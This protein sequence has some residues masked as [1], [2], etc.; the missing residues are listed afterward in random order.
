M[1]GLQFV[2]DNGLV[3]SSLIERYHKNKLHLELRK[4]GEFKLVTPA[5][6][7]SLL[8]LKDFRK[9]LCPL[10]SLSIRKIN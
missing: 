1:S 7:S 10:N 8:H 9:S 5:Y 2:Q 6:S 3:G 4:T